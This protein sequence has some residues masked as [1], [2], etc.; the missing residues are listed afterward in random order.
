MTKRLAKETVF[1]EGIDKGINIIY[2]DFESQVCEN[3]EHLFDAI[4]RDENHNNITTPTC[5]E[6]IL[7]DCVLCP[8]PD[9]GCN[10]FTKKDNK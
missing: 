3:C 5:L 7:E 4:T 10:K 8:E 9:F 2:D 1:K 6:F